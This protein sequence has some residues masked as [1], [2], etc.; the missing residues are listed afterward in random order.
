MKHLWIKK[1]LICLMFEYSKIIF[2]FR[3]INPSI[4]N[5][6]ARC[7]TERH[8]T[9]DA[10]RVHVSSQVTAMITCLEMFGNISYV[11]LLAFTK[12]T[13]LIS[14]IHV[15]LIY[16]IILPYSYLMNTS[17]NKTRIV[18]YG[19]K[20][21]FKNLT[22]HSSDSVVSIDNKLKND[23]PAAVAEMRQQKPLKNGEDG[24]I[25]TITKHRSIEQSLET[26][27]F[28]A[29]QEPSTSKEG[30]S[31][32]QKIDTHAQPSSNKASKRRNYQEVVIEIVSYMIRYI[33][34]EEIYI[35]YFKQLVTFDAHYK[36]G[37]PVSEF[38]VTYQSTSSLA[39]TTD[40]F[41]HEHF[42][43]ENKKSKSSFNV[44]A[45][46]DKHCKDSSNVE[47]LWFERAS[48]RDV[49][50]HL[51]GRIR[52]RLNILNDF[53]RSHNQDTNLQESLVESLIDLEESFIE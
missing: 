26:E 1:L 35:E 12:K 9:F 10:R 38:D 25:F 48:K 11:I 16:H 3:K 17:H 21:V 51:V 14:L 34:D 53:S 40:A 44:F 27:S 39:L 49:K 43:H 31:K 33:M 7:L 8:N 42:K 45:R 19:W 52:Q 36:M 37:K 13:S 23:G 30:Y 18:D 50:G 46:G 28:S 29:L 2:F 47:E 20:N 24:R 4:N 6:G 32:K 15:M 22:G 41:R 5:L